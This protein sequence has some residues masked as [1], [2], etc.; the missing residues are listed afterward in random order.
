MNKRNAL[1]LSVATLAMSLL[2][3]FPAAANDK[4]EANQ[5]RWLKMIREQIPHVSEPQ[6]Q[7]AIA[8]SVAFLANSGHASEALEITRG[9]NN[10][11]TKN[12]L[13]ISIATLSAQQLAFDTALS[14]VN[15]IDEPVSKERAYHEVARALAKAG[16]LERAERLMQDLSEPYFQER[17][18]A[19]I[20]EHLA[21]NGRFEEALHR[22][23]GITDSYRN[24]EVTKLIARVRTG[25]IRPLEQLSGSLRNH[26]HTLSILAN[27][28]TYDSAIL[29]IVAAKAGDRATALEHIKAT[30]GPSDSPK[31]PHQRIPMAILASVAFV[32][33]GD[34]EAAGDLVVK[35][36]NSTDKDW[37]GI[38][39]SFGTPILM[40]L[41]VRLERFDAIEEIVKSKRDEFRSNQKSSWYLFTLSSLA[42]SLIEQGRYV[43]FES[44]LNSDNTPDERL[45]LLIGAIVGADYARKAKP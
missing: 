39:T 32:E 10:S 40:S 3:S 25:T 26:I 43:E 24:D 15:E 7:T 11:D 14:T 23:K 21:R 35:L 29:A 37:S 41:L 8:M 1:V 34:K 13:M 42:E 36:Y 18:L 4:L 5:A 45:Y 17:V 16:E 44:W 9:V 31:I 30:L 2:V 38:S 12:S 22:A 20:C 27:D 33:L 19:E 28:E 6:Q